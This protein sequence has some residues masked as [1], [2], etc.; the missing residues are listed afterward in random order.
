MQFLLMKLSLESISSSYL[1]C[2]HQKS[3][4]LLSLPA[5]R[6]YLQTLTSLPRPTPINRRLSLKLEVEDSRPLPEHPGEDRSQHVV[7]V[8]SNMMGDQTQTLSIT[9]FRHKPL[10]QFIWL[11]IAQL[12]KG[13]KKKEILDLQMIFIVNGSF[14]QLPSCLSCQLWLV[15]HIFLTDDLNRLLG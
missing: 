14:K 3:F 8:P 4:Q 15:A 7:P 1:I 12:H 9:S 11:L 2:M 6:R 10:I 13:R 5:I